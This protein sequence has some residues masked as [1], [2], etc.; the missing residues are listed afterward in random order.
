MK[1]LTIILILLSSFANA[2]LSKQDLNL[3]VATL[4]TASLIT[5][6][7]TAYSLTGG[8]ETDYI[9]NDKFGHYW[10]MSVTTPLILLTT[11]KPLLAILTG[12]S[13]LVS[14]E[15]YDKHYKK[16]NFNFMDIQ[17]GLSAIAISYIFYK[18]GN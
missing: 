12:C 14:K 8:F 2:Q 9:Q 16:T 17:A 3:K 5:A 6:Y 4:S 10:V 13:I 11:H 18:I 7:H 1:K 15:L